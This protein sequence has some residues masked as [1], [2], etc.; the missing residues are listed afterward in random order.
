MDINIFVIHTEALAIRKQRLDELFKHVR[1]STKYTFHVEYVMDHE[2]NKLD[3]NF[4][5]TVFSVN[6]KSVTDPQ[7]QGLSVD[8][9]L[10]QVSSALKHASA[11]QKAALSSTPSIILEDDVL[12]QEDILVNLETVLDQFSD[13]GFVFLGM[14]LQKQVET[15][16]KETM[17]IPGNDHYT[18]FPCCDSYIVSPQVAKTLSSCIFPIKFSA[19]IHLSYLLKSNNITPYVLTKNIFVDG[20]KFGVYLCSMDS[21]TFLPFNM[22]FIRL[23]QLMRTPFDNT[24]AIEEGLRTA[25]FGNHP[26]IL[27]IHAL[28]LKEKKQYADAITILGNAVD[29]LKQNNCIV[30]GSNPILRNY[31]SLFQYVQ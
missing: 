27:H 31:I 7:F 29:I 11:I 3:A 22:E 25:K 30:N 2:P 28:Y 18:V 5:K 10:G 8:L 13:S 24:D 12:F 1:A 16:T 17:I 15:E 19:N 21:N 4:V 20:T 26:A 14:P 9:N 23:I 6:D